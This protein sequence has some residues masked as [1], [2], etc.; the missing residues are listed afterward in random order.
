MKT[1]SAIFSAED[2]RAVEAAVAE[3]ER[4][5]AGEIVVVVATISGRYD[6]AEDLF[7]LLFGLIALSVAWLLFQDVTQAAWSATPTPVLGLPATAGILIGGFVIGAALATRFPTLRLPFIARAE[8]VE[9]VERRSLE[10]FQRQRIRN[11][12]GNTGVLI[13][14]SLYEHVVKVIGDDGVAVQF[15]IDSLEDI[16]SLVVDG[17][18]QGRPADGLCR[19]VKKTGELLAPHLPPAVGSTNE[20]ANQLILID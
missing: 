5:T 20:I 4:M 15:S 14:V 2:K 17:L 6:R 16:C 19:A 8:M 18:R 13:Y 1:A 10:F 11:T 12:S 9:E 3:A 7:G